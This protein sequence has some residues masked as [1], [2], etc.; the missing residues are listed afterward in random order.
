MPSATVMVQMGCGFG[1]G[2]APIFTSTRHWRAGA[3]RA[4]RV[5]QGV[6][7]EARDDDAKALAGADQQLA[8]GRVDLPP[9]D[10][11]PDV[12]LGHRPGFGLLLGSDGHA[13][14]P[15]S[16]AN[17]SGC[18]T[19]GCSVHRSRNSWRKYLIPLV[20][21]L[22]APSPSAQNERPRMLSQMSSIVSTS[23]GVPCLWTSRSR[24]C[25][26]QYV[27][28]RHGVHLPQLSCL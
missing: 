2:R 25:S 26:S 5:E 28:S 21:G 10:R 19:D 9:V 4:R 11:E 15:V 8:L 1:I 3:A 23:A 24:I 22:T 7:A 27:P 13:E 18:A 12:A 6:V 14:S 17:W 16:S 20:I